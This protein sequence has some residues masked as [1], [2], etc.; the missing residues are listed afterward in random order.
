MTTSKLA[1]VVA[2]ITCVASLTP[3]AAPGRCT[4]VIGGQTVSGKTHVIVTP[5]KPT[6]QEARAA[7]DLQAHVEKLTGQALAIVTDGRAGERAPIVVGRCTKTLAALGV[8]VDFASLGLEGIVIRTKG[9]ALV[10]GG[11]RRGVLYAVYTFLEDYC[12]V[13][14][15]TP[16]CTVMPKTG[17]LKIPAINVRYIP[18]LEYR[19]TDYPCHRDADFAVRNKYNGTQTQLDEA[20]GGKIAYSHF[21]HTFNSI[22]DPRTHFAKHPEYFSMIKGKRQAGRTQLCLTN[23]DV[24]A[25]A[26]RPSA[27][28]SKPPPP[29]QSSASRRTTGTPTANAPPAPS[30]PKR[31]AR[32][33]GP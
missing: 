16:D 20:R 31:K 22:L 13:R 32:R 30:S 23:P 14:W 33:P 28:G 11:N 4:I 19:A 3:A 26:R 25:I 9:A 5:A 10:L 7:E 1:A 29:R 27:N 6:P 2:V 21:V 24:I 17:A 12:S 18:P 15:L 8:K